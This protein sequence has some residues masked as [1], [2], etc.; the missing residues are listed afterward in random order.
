MPDR[1]AR[2][3]HGALTPSHD[4]YGGR[5]PFASSTKPTMLHRYVPVRSRPVP[6][7]GINEPMTGRE[8]RRATPRGVVG[9]H[10]G[11]HEVV[12]SVALLPPIQ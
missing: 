5:S 6:E 11:M 8:R 2:G 10:R 4:A 12:E 3:P 1:V 7:F 9:G